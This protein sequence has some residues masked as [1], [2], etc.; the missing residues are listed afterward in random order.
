MEFSRFLYV[1]INTF[2][3]EKYIRNYEYYLSKCI[4]SYEDYRL[5]AAFI[6][7]DDIQEM[8]TASSNLG[9]TL[10]YRKIRKNE[11]DYYNNMEGIIKEY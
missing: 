3:H 9:I 1:E 7:D 10:T 2:L 11:L 6:L 4:E 5:V 8:K